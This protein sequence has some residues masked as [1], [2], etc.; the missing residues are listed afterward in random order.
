M[1][2]IEGGAR[3]ELFVPRF[4]VH[5]VDNL[6]ITYV[7]RHRSKYAGPVRIFAR[8]VERYAILADDLVFDAGSLPYRRH[9]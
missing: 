6:A 3:S 2:G 9:L 4:D 1:V 5:L 7:E 8:L